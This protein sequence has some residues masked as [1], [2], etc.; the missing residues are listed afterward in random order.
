M[1]KVSVFY[2]NELAGI[3][4]KTVDDQFFFTYEEDYIQSLNPSI[5]LTLP[6]EKIKFESSDLFAFFDG[7]IPEGWLLNLAST[8]L[9]LNPLRD[10]FELLEKLCQET[11]GAV[12]IGEKTKASRETLKLPSEKHNP[13]IYGKCLIC[14]EKSK[15]IYHDE[16][17]IKVFGKK[18]HPVVDIN[19]EILETLAKKQLNQKLALAGAQ[20]KLSLELQEDNKQSRM[21][22]TDLWG[23][24]IFKPKGSPPHLPENEH[25][26]LKLAESFKIQI[27][28]GALIPT[29]TGEL[30]FIAQRFDRTE[31]HFEFH[32]EDFCQILDKPAYKKY[33]GSLEQVGKILKKHSDFPGDNLYRLY[34]L[35]LFNY[36]I[37]NVDFHLKNISLIYENVDG[38][39]KVLSP[40]YDVI[41]TDLYI[42]DDNEESALAI[43]GKKNQLNENDF[44]ALADNFGIPP[45]VHK[46]LIKKFRDHL[47]VWDGFIEKSFLEDKKKDEFKQLI[48]E[49]LSRFS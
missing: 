15:S 42:E 39:K 9:R 25:L 13:K 38:Y 6:K 28:K 40:A 18:I 46:N 47:P 36:I 27:E 43:N 35:T 17:M 14:Y 19:E 32:Q 21:T 31:K 41:S 20:K 48:R 29:S 23:R 5:S 34:E 44:L 2:K 37:G 22:V 12:H 45:K 11:I 49:K 24:Y 10:R 3:L 1:S 26:C 8:E 33:N 16:C 30:G 4:E 7:L